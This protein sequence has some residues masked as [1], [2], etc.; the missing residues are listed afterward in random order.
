LRPR[1]VGESARFQFTAT[2]VNKG[3]REVTLEQITALIA[4][5]PR[6]E[7]NAVQIDNYPLTL[8]LSL[9]Q[10][11]PS[12]SAR[13]VQAALPDSV[14]KLRSVDST[15]HF[16]KLMLDFVTL[17]SDGVRHNKQS[18]GEIRLERQASAFD[19]LSFLDRDIE[20]INKTPKSTQ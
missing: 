3:P 18:H 14:N 12:G 5:V 1:P 16:I 8:N 15:S 9:P 6:P 4:V 13:D 7:G 10:I 20:L 19:G 2:L 11:I 17:D